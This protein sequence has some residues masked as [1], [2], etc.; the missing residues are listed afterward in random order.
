MLASV[1]N[2]TR[3]PACRHQG[4]PSRNVVPER[5]NRSSFF[6]LPDI[7]IEARRAGATIASSCYG[8][9]KIV[10]DVSSARG[11][12]GAS[13]RT[14]DQFRRLEPSDPFELAL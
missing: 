2:K 3:I 10:D 12:D 13:R 4:L 8:A 9:F 7:D 1:S 5:T 14:S 6:S 11:I